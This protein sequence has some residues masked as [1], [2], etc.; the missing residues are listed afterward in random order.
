MARWNVGRFLE[1]LSFFRAVPLVGSLPWLAAPTEAAPILPGP[2]RG[3]ADVT[4]ID[5]A[6]ATTAQRQLWGSLDDVVMGGVSRSG[7]SWIAE[8]ARFSG[9]VSTANSGGFA[10]VRSRNLEPPLNLSGYRG[11]RLQLR[12]DGNRYKFFLRDSEGWDSLAYAQAFDTV[13][14]QEITV[15]LPFE[16]FQPVFRARI[17]EAPPLNQ[18]SIRSLQVM[19]SKF[20]FDRQLNPRFSAGPFQLDLIRL[21]AY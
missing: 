13:A 3:E 6:A 15:D 1:T 12:G 17:V 5:F 8:G 10:S 21:S 20:E 18:A 4:V 2:P 19:L 9:E 11:L 7:L 14:G 16:R